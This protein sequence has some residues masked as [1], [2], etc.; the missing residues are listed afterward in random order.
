MVRSVGGARSFRRR[1]LELG[2]VPGTAIQVV[3]RVELG[4]V[5]EIELRD[6]RVSLR[7]SEAQ[8]LELESDEP[9]APSSPSEKTCG[10]CCNAAVETPCE[11]P[12]ATDRS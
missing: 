4:D 5:L 3:R 10:S 6:S 8:V 2:F 12:A 11:T 9:Q 7:I 1:L